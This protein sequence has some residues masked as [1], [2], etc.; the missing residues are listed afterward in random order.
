[1]RRPNSLELLLFLSV[2]AT[3]ACGSESTIPTEPTPVSVTETFSGTI[4]RNGAA[5]HIFVAQTAG[6]VTATLTSVAPDSAV[7]IGV[8]LGTWNG[9]S[10]HIVLANDNALQGAVVTGSASS[11]GNLC[12]RVYD[13]GKVVDATDYVVTVVHP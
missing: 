12:V 2:V 8:S 7:A 6:P 5:T 1:M 10:C 9:S 4:N 13:V 3:A 11:I